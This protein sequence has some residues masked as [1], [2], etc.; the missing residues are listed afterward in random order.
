[1]LR[2]IKETCCVYA[3]WILVLYFFYFYMIYLMNLPHDEQLLRG[4]NV[5]DEL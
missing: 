5:R 3:L 2:H 1:M 4:R